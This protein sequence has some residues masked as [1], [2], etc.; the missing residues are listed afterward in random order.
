MVKEKVDSSF[1]KSVSY[2]EEENSMI[3]K[4]EGKDKDRDYKYLDVKKETFK[5]FIESESKGRFYTSYIKGNYESV[6]LTNIAE[7]I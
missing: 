2:N 6:P 3:V 1:I 7:K 5:D 4:M